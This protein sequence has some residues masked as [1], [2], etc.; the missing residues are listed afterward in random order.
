MAGVAVKAGAN[1]PIRRARTPFTLARVSWRKAML[2][3]GF[4]LLE[5][6]PTKTAGNAPW[7]AAL[8]APTRRGSMARGAARRDALVV[9]GIAAAAKPLSVANPATAKEA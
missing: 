5:T 2:A 7:R 8:G 1:A 4:L 3:M 9:S 6:R